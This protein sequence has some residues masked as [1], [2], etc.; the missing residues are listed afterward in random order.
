M[1]RAFETKNVGDA[2]LAAERELQDQ[3]PAAGTPVRRKRPQRSPDAHV[4]DA[5]RVAYDETVREQ[6]PDEFLDLLGKLA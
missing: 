5:L 3:Q 2:G 6:V 4:A 1:S